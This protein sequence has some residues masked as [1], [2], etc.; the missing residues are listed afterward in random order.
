MNKKSWKRSQLSIKYLDRFFRNKYLYEIN[1]RDIEEYKNK[2]IEAGVKTSTINRELACL[3]M[4]LNKAIEWK[5]L[6]TGLPRIKLFKED[7]ERVRYLEKE[8][9]KQ[10]L[11]IAGEPLKTIILITL[12][13]GMV[14]TQSTSVD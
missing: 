8:E 12:H 13:T 11:K 4:M 6:K 5:Y 3:K 2:R 7:N 10:I 9:I 14:N 1:N